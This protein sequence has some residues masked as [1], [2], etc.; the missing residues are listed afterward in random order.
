MRSK[1]EHNLQVACV[2]WFR[3]QY[4]QYAKLLIAVPNGGSRNKIEAANLK[5]EGV[6]AGVCDLLLLV[7]RN[8]LGCAG[9]ELKSP[10]GSLRPT[11]RE[12]ACEFGV[13]N[14]WAVIRSMEKF[15]AE[16][17]LYLER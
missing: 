9:F 10:N 2:T 1:T 6:V 16:V 17:K 8:G 3:L 7:P 11:Q 14:Y 15:R 5:K 13:H 12:W 4:P